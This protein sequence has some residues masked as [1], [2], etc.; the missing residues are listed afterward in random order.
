M[1]LKYGRPYVAA[2]VRALHTTRDS[3]I[4]DPV[5]AA[6]TLERAAAT[7][8]DLNTDLREFAHDLERLLDYVEHT[9]AAD[10]SRVAQIDFLFSRR[11]IALLLLRCW[12]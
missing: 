6:E 7:G 10:D 3:R 12:S 8:P 4:V 1:L 5:L 11:H 2:Q 9:E